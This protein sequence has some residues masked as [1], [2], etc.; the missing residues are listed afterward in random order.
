MPKPLKPTLRERNRYIVFEVIS[1]SKPDRKSVVDA[2]WGSLLRLHGELGASRTSMWVMDYDPEKK[3]GIL[4]VNH[5]SVDVLK[6]SMAVVKEI[7]RQKA[8]INTVKT[9]GTLRKA[10]EIL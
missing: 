8:I 1:D 5:S 10:R 6:S 2:V 3:R 4:K 9:S 7:R